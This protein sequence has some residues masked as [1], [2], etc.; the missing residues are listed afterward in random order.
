[1]LPD[2]ELTA[3]QKKYLDGLIPSSSV[4]RQEPITYLNS[5]CNKMIKGVVGVRALEELSNMQRLN[6]YGLQR[7]HHVQ[8]TFRALVDAMIPFSPLHASQEF[9]ALALGVDEYVIWELDHS[10]AVQREM[11][12]MNIPLAA[13]TAGMLNA[14]ATQLIVTGQTECMTNLP[15]FALCS[16]FAALSVRDRF[17][18]ISLLEQLQIDLGVLPSPYTNNAGLVKIMA[19]TLN[20]YVMFGYYSEWAAYGSTRLSTPECRSIQ[21][22]PPSWIQ[23][24]YPGPAYGYRD[25][26]GFLLRYAQVRGN[27]R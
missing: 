24:G 9:G 27:E 8:A 11:N 3:W 12:V 22:F 10:L 6:M 20:I 25:F 18:A 15:V 13:P 16:P 5:R 21:F 4:V 1:M 7:N 23:V 17:R 19:N 26:R 2:Q 14:A